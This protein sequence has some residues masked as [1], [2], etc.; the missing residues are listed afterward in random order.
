[1]K[2]DIRI[3]TRSSKLALWQANFVKTF[4]VSNFNDLKVDIV[5]IVTTGDKRQGTRL[6]SVEGKGVFVKE[7]EDSLINKD[8]DIAVHSYKDVPINLPEELEIIATSNRED[9]RDVLIAKSRR[10]LGDLEPNSILGTGSL[11]RTEQ[12]KEIRPDIQVEPI[13]GNVDTRIR[14]VDSDEYD[15]VVVAYAG[16]RRLGLEERVSQI[17]GINELVPRRLQGFLAVESRHDSGMSKY[18]QNFSDETNLLVSNYERKF[19]K[20]LNLG[21][22]FPVGLC[23]QIH[24]SKIVFSYFIKGSKGSKKNYFESDYETLDLTYGKLL[25]EVGSVV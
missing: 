4:L 2:V 5:P 18:F 6:D 8:I 25:S 20:D 22:E 21:C 24:D 1:M 16:I 7:I 10:S 23:M 19:L 3:G 11:R 13:R 17:F 15:G 9:P 14:K 12:I